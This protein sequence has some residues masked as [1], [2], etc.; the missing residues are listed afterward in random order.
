MH[1]Q[2][3]LNP[4]EL[5]R[6]VAEKYISR[7]ECPYGP[8]VLYNYTER[9]TYERMWTPETHIC[10]GLIIDTTD[11]RVVARPF[12]KFHNIDEPG[13]PESA[14]PALLELRGPIEATEKLDGSL[15]VLWFDRHAEVWRCSTRGSFT[16]TQARDATTW[17]AAHLDTSALFPQWTYL[18]EWI[19]PHNRVVIRYDQPELRLIG[20]I[21]IDGH[22]C[23]ARQLRVIAKRMG[24][25]SVRETEVTSLVDF[26]AQTKSLVGV[27]GWVL[28]WPDGFRVKVKTEEYLRLHRIIS[29]FGPERVR[30]MLL[31]GGLGEYIAALPD[32]FQDEARAIAEDITTRTAARIAALEATYQRLAPLLR[33]GRKAYALAVQAEAPDDRP[34]LFLLA[35][36]K[37]ITDRVIKSLVLSERATVEG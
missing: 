23:G 16:S 36:Q 22:D 31:T 29:F 4:N 30:E 14:L 24:L 11:D 1:I 25:V 13:A 8:Y 15:I 37:S 32:E 6:L 27:E 21:M 35:D 3:L 19:A 20:A 26:I 33:E 9:A 2:D 12:I 18:F 10:R 17:I 28:R 34:Y 5:D 7:V